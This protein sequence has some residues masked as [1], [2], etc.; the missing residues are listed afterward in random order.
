MELVEVTDGPV[1]IF[2][3]IVTA[4]LKVALFVTADVV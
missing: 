4:A 3:P 1:H 2:P